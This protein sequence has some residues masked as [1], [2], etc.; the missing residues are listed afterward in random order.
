LIVADAV[1]I[2][3]ESNRQFS[4]IGSIII[5]NIP[6]KIILFTVIER[7]T[8]TVKNLREKYD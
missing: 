5:I 1:D 3:D 2:D 6:F 4:H 8:K 7:E